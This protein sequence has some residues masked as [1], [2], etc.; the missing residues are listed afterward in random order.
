MRQGPSDPRNEQSWVD[1]TWGHRG[2]NC[3]TASATS[4]EQS[5]NEHACPI[6]R[7][8]ID[9]VAT[10]LSKPM[11]VAFSWPRLHGALLCSAVFV[12]TLFGTG[13]AMSGP[14]PSTTPELERKPAKAAEPP[15]YTVKRGS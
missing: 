2:V 3:A 7:G 11:K 1:T 10:Q 13:S 14:N 12:L 8:R 6:V 15:T 4:N 5:S 9:A